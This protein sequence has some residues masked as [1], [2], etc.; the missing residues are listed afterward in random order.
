MNERPETSFSLYCRT[1]QLLW[2][3]NNERKDARETSS[4]LECT[5]SE[6]AEFEIKRLRGDGVGALVVE[7]NQ[8]EQIVNACEE[9]PEFQLPYFYSLKLDHLIFDDRLLVQS[10]RCI[11]Q[12][13]TMK[14][15]LA[16]YF[17][18]G[19]LTATTWLA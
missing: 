6:K 11:S 4:V 7:K 15:A 18:N 1:R 8:E 5:P 16:E 13:V 12:Q 3:W 14:I 19:H 10:Y 9:Q 17:Q 2:I